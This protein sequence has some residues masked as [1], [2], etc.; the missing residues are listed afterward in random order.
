MC[1]HTYRAD[2]D[3]HPFPGPLEQILEMKSRPKN[4]KTQLLHTSIYKIDNQQGP[5][6]WH[7]ELCSIFCNNLHGKRI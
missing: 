2:L 5:S 4:K 3:P 6:V 7:R 1:R